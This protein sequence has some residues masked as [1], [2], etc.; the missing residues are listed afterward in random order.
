MLLK[1][2][3]VQRVLKLILFFIEKK[4]KLSFCCYFRQLVTY[5]NH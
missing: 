2:V 3:R 5:S 4:L 1:A